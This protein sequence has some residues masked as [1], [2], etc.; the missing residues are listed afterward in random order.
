MKLLMVCFDSCKITPKEISNAMQV[1][2]SMKTTLE[3]GFEFPSTFKAY[4]IMIFCRK[5]QM[6]VS[7]FQTRKEIFLVEGVASTFPIYPVEDIYQG[8]GHIVKCF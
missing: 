3:K 1:F 6:I 4:M 8:K 7:L 2:H 5:V